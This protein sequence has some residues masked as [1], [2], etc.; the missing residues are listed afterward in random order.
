MNVIFQ[1]F[2]YFQNMSINRRWLEQVNYDW[3]LRYLEHISSVVFVKCF[4]TRENGEL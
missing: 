1:V 4:G 3:F 2:G